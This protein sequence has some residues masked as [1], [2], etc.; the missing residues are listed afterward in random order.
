MPARGYDADMTRKHPLL[1]GNQASDEVSPGL[2]VVLWVFI[3]GL[4][5]APAIFVF[6]LVSG[7]AED[8]ESWAAGSI[9]CILVALLL[10][11]G[12]RSSIRDTRQLRTKGVEGTATVLS[13]ESE[14]DGQSLILRVSVDG[15]E[16][17]DARAR[18]GGWSRKTVGETVD[19]VVDPEDLLFTV[20]DH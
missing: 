11:A 12:V 6:R 1:Q 10:F 19:V 20:V 8:A 17:F 2:L 5:V 4:L 13:V 18:S 3:T 7:N 14:D 9:V 15:L 16:P